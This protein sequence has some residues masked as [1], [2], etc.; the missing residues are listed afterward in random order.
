MLITKISNLVQ[1]RSPIFRLSL[2]SQRVGRLY[3]STHLPPL[4]S[5]W[6]GSFSILRHLIKS[7]LNLNLQKPSPT[8]SLCQEFSLTLFFCIILFLHSDKRWR[9]LD[10]RGGR[11]DRSGSRW[12]SRG[13]YVCIKLIC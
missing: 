8:R 1:S 5:S 4:M 12:K 3:V 2:L 6:L 11:C 9:D 10:H 13:S 7:T